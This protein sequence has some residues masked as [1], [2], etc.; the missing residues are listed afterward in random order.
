MVEKQSAD[1]NVEPTGKRIAKNVVHKELAIR[2]GKLF[3]R[4][5]RM[6]NGCGA[7]V[8]AIHFEFRVRAGC[9]IGYLNCQVAVST[10]YIQDTKL[11]QVSPASDVRYRAPEIIRCAAPRIDSAQAI[12][13]TNAAGVIE[14]RIV[15]PF[16]L[17][18][19]LTDVHVPFFRPNS[20]L[21]INRF[22]AVFGL[23]C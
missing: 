6:T 1:D 13:S 3:R 19:S 23:L 14:P 5:R 22:P 2:H 15:H 18:L 9:A 7:N 16:R 12:E 21:H 11:I 4:G 20:S 17:Q 8:A 10:R